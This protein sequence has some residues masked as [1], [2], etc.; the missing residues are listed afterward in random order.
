MFLLLMP[1]ADRNAEAADDE[2]TAYSATVPSHTRPSEAV[3]DFTRLCSGSSEM[4]IEQFQAAPALKW[5]IR[6]GWPR[7]CASVFDHI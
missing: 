2:P 1:L 3:L 5:L 4:H 7:M 6:Q